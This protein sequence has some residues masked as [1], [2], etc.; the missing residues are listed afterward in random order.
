[1]VFFPQNTTS[2]MTFRL[3]EL[4]GKQFLSSSTVYSTVKTTVQTRKYELRL[5]IPELAQ[6]KRKLLDFDVLG[7]PQAQYCQLLI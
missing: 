3:V 6:P 7:K 5:G 2:I 4:C 1:M